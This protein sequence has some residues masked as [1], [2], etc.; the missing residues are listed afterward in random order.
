MAPLNI[1]EPIAIASAQLSHPFIP[2]L[3]IDRRR[4]LKVGVKLG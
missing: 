4:Y 3:T 1:M 2:P